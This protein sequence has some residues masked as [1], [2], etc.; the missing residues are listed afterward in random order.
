M[1]LERTF[2][3][4]EC[5]G[6]GCDLEDGCDNPFFTDSG[7]FAEEVA[8]D[9]G[10]IKV[11]GRHYCEECHHHGDNDELILGDGTVIQPDEADWI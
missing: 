4:V 3:G 5:D 9:S 2:Y 7:V 11:R 6:C 1:I 8:R 10:W